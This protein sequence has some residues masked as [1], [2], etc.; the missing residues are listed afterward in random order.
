MAGGEGFFIE[1]AGGGGVDQEAFVGAV[2]LD[3]DDGEAIAAL[4][5]NFAE[6]GSG[7]R[8]GGG[9]RVCVCACRGLGVGAWRLRGERE[10]KQQARKSDRKQTR[11]DSHHFLDGTETVTWSMR[12]KIATLA[13]RK[14]DSSRKRRE[15]QLPPMSSA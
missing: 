10:R 1:H 3:D 13:E 11:S 2:Y 6:V 15:L 14:A 8:R 5:G 12:R 9:V 4:Q 7:A